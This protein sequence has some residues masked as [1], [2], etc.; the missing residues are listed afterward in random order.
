MLKKTLLMIIS[1]VIILINTVLGCSFHNMLPPTDPADY[2]DTLYIEYEMEIPEELEGVVVGD[3]N[4]MIRTY[5][6][7][8]E[9]DDYVW[10]ENAMG[11]IPGLYAIP[12]GNIDKVQQDKMNLDVINIYLND[13][14]TIDVDTMNQRDNE[15]N[16][17]YIEESEGV[18]YLDVKEEYMYLYEEPT[19][20]PEENEES[21]NF[22][23]V[24]ENYIDKRDG[25]AEELGYI[26]RED[27]TEIME[28]ASYFF[29]TFW[30]RSLLAMS[31][32]F[33]AIL[34]G[35][36]INRKSIE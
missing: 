14:T 15:Y 4:N 2:L 24:V 28:Q 35:I 30:F 11:M 32:M 12:N 18:L 10:I 33:L 3:E 1:F 13:G 34:Y 7:T 22:V 8:I 6:Y 27:K 21:S 17:F 5:I 9:T 25:L 31:I 20:E 26:E 36:L 29:E 16:V 19:D 23:N